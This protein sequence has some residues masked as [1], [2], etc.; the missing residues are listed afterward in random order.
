MTTFYFFQFNYWQKIAKELKQRFSLLY[1]PKLQFRYTFM[2]FL[3]LL[4]S[5]NANAQGVDSSSALQQAPSFNLSDL[6][7]NQVH[8]NAYKDKYLV[9]H[10]ATTWCPFCNAEAPYLEQLYQEYQDKNV[11]VLI[12]DVKESQELVKEKLQDRF[13]FTFPLL[14]DENGTVAASFAPDDVLPELAR[15]EVMLA[16]NILIDPAGNIRFLSMLDSKNFDARLIALQAKLDE[17]L[18]AQ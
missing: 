2:F 14:L 13:N 10:I 8:S 1:T 15:D 5:I 3:T 18:T 7:G 6:N 12:I 9:I 16:S 4:I 17:L 11:A